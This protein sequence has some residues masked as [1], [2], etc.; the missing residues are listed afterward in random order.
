MV[1]KNRKVVS[2]RRNLRKPVGQKYIDG[3]EAVGF[4]SK[5]LFLPEE[6][7]TSATPFYLKENE[8]SNL[9]VCLENEVNLRSKNEFSADSVQKEPVH[10]EKPWGYY[11]IIDQGPHYKVKKIV[12]NPGNRL[13]LQMHFHRN[14]YWL[15]TRGK[16]FVTIGDQNFFLFPNQSTYIPQQTFHRME[17]RGNETLEIIEVQN[18]NCISEEDIV[19]IEDDFNRSEII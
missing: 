1:R 14:E 16:A 11:V 13:S 15:V 10:I 12:V 17:N 6:K 7:S 9:S 8:K 19:R 18:G 2:S 5:S 3:N 4:L